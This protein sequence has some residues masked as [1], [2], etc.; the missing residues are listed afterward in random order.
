MNNTSIY[1]SGIVY[2]CE[3]IDF[4]SKT[5]NAK[6]MCDWFNTRKD[7]S[8]KETIYCKAPGFTEVGRILREL[9]LNE[10]IPN[11]YGGAYGDEPLYLNVPI[12]HP[13]TKEFLH[14]ADLYELTHTIIDPFAKE[15]H[16]IIVDRYADSTRAYAIGGHRISSTWIETLLSL[17]N[18]QYPNYVLYFRC[19]VDTA[20][21]RRKKSGTRDGA[22]TLSGEFYQS[23]YEYYE[24]LRAQNTNWL[25]IDASLNED[26]VFEQVLTLVQA[27]G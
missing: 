24:Y 23:V 7:A 4:S 1:G 8:T 22:D 6:K 25:D 9:V 19:P 11:G 27:H 20:L 3:G 16:R 12:R 17:L 21:A 15:G 5:T 2:T 13:F 10:R 14:V 26:A 18:T